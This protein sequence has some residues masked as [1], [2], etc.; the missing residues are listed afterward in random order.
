MYLGG[1]QTQIKQQQQQPVFSINESKPAKQQF[2]SASNGT[3]SAKFFLNESDRHDLM[4]VR[5]QKSKLVAAA[6]A[7]VCAAAARKDTSAADVSNFSNNLSLNLSIHTAEEFGTEMLEWLNGEATLAMTTAGSTSAATV[8]AAAATCLPS[9]SGNDCSV[10][11]RR[12]AINNATL[13]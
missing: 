11:E 10:E 4:P 7:D 8:T 5:A 9:G 1:K 6:T 13:V 2:V 12:E 3:S